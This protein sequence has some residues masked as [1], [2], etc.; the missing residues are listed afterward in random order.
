MEWNNGAGLDL[1]FIYSVQNI[2]G[3]LVSNVHFQSKIYPRVHRLID[4]CDFMQE[5]CPF[6]HLILNKACLSPVYC[7]PLILKQFHY[8][9]LFLFFKTAVG[10]NCKADMDFSS[11]S[12]ST[13]ERG[14]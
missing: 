10:T 13:P 14:N 8:S 3:L 4:I 1:N 11:S 6:W 12:I 9:H 7:A 5:D 2:P